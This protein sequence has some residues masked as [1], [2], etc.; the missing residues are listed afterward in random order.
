MKLRGLGDEN[1]FDEIS[2]SKA[3]NSHSICQFKQ[4]IAEEDFN[5]Y[6]SAV[7]K[8]IGVELDNGRPI[9]FGQVEEV[10]I[11]QTFRGSYVE[12]KARSASTKIDEKAATRI[13]QSPD[14]KFGEILN[15]AR[16]ELKDC[17]LELDGK[18]SAKSCPE[19][20]LQNDETAFEFIK[21]LAKWQGQRVWVKDTQNGKCG[22]KVAPC[23][24]D[25]PNELPQDEII[26][27]KVGRRGEIHTAELVSSKYFELGRVLELEG[28]NCKFLIIAQEIFRLN[29]V[30]VIRYELEEFKELPVINFQTAAP[31]KLKAEVVEIDD[32]ENLGRLHVKFEIE[33]KDAKKIF[34]PYRTPYSGIIFMPEVGDTVEVFYSLGECFV[35]SVLR[36]KSL[37][38]EFKKVTDKYLSN[39]RKQRIFFREK[40]LELKSTDTS[41]FMDDKKII[42]SVG[43]N[44]ITLDEKGITIKTGG[45]LTEDI[46]KDFLLKVGGKFSSE[47]ASDTS[48]KAGGKFTA[49]AS[50]AA[51]IGGS[52][53]ELG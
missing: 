9:F 28:D 4:R 1:Y 53:V 2:V 52:S 13:F 16:L 33:D 8:I 15:P 26:R 42:L 7:G 51:Q 37:D 17:S 6:R 29:G 18:L 25:S 5:L 24:D 30:D 36:T 20:I 45:A 14:K 12:V 41:I 11:E 22:L 35:S 3:A 19:I 27:L 34:L 49:K 43:E 31:V 21:R 50:G 46:A 48:F 23:A 10:V 47:S 38:E 40:S 44:K 39:N 32:S